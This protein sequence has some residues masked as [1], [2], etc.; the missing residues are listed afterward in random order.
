MSDIA[1]VGCRGILRAGLVKLLMELGFNSVEEADSIQQLKVESAPEASSD[2]LIVC[3]AQEP[4]E[5][6]RVLDDLKRCACS[7]RAVFVAREFDLALM[8]QC[9]AGGASGY[10]LDTILPGVL[11]DSLTLLKAGEKV[12]P[13]QFATLLPLMA[14][15]RDNF[16]SERSAT[17]FDNNTSEDVHLTAQEQK[18][19]ER[20]VQGQ[21]NKMIAQNLRIAEP[22]V[23]IHIKRILRKTG[24]SN[25]TQ[26]ALW[27]VTK[28]ARQSV[29][30][31]SIAS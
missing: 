19:L 13:S 12:F 29:T 25:R 5:I 6:A 27:G 7:A 31:L 23:K 10:L 30:S 14:T 21:T 17:K 18:I 3:V 22:T 11:K 15:Q 8:R 28:A 4:K 24:L 2:A 1:V 20:L 26:L 16:A 9:F